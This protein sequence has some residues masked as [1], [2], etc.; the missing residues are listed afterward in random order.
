M[1]N[2]SLPLL[3]LVAFFVIACAPSAVLTEELPTPIP[4]GNRKQL[5]HAFNRHRN[6]NNQFPP[7]GGLS[8]SHVMGLDLL[9]HVG[10]SST[11]SLREVSVA[12]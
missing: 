1:K 7:C 4:T 11:R 10:G 3:L 5:Q 9:F 6:L 2:K 8:V 12:R